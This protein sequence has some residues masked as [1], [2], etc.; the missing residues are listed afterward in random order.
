MPIPSSMKGKR[1][2]TK[3]MHMCR[4]SLSVLTGPTHLTPRGVGGRVA[5]GG[6][7]GGFGGVARA[8]SPSPPPQ[9]SQQAS[10]PQA[11][12]G[13]NCGEANLTHCGP[14]SHGLRCES[15]KA[16]DIEIASHCTTLN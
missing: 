10:Q 6:W 1:Y 7:V 12:V 3:G 15:S 16:T 13:A 5:V 11:A 4:V 14:P 8:Q 9:A 2:L